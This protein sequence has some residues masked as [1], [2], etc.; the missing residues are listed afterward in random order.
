MTEEKI[1]KWFE[2]FMKLPREDF[3]DDYK[4][5]FPKGF[6]LYCYKKGL[7]EKIENEQRKDTDK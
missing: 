3:L 1:Q 6:G 4:D 7:T 2:E 5:W